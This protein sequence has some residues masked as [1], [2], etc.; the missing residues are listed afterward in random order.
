MDVLFEDETPWL[1]ELGCFLEDRGIEASDVTEITMLVKSNPD[2]TDG[3]ALVTKLL[4]SSQI[5]FVGTDAVSVTI[6]TTDYGS[7]KME[8]GGSYY[9]YLGFTATGYTGAYLEARLK[10]HM[11][12]IIQDGVRD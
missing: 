7:G 3:A 12:T 9:V 8:I 6:A 10:N 11:I 1:F 5:A 4:G 2:D